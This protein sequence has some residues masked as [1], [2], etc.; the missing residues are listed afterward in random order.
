MKYA[1]IAISGT[2][3]QVEENQKIVVDNLNLKEEEKSSTDQ[4]LLTVNED[5]VSVGAPTV[6]DA[7]VEFK[8]IKNFKGEKIRV[9][10]YKSKSRYRKTTGFRAQLTEIQITKI[11]F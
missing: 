8:V 7:S 11:N 6:K 10:K 4:V 1:V 5:K 2:Q 3:H 9:F